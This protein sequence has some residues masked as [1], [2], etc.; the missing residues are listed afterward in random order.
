MRDFPNL[1]LSAHPLAAV[2]LARLRD[3]TTAPPAFRTALNQVA[4]LLVAEA[5]ADLPLE[6]TTV[7]TPLASAPAARLAAPV[8][9]FPV[10]RAGLGLL[11]AAQALLPDAPVWHVGLYRDE[12]TLQPVAY[13]ERLP[14]LDPATAC[15]ALDP[16][17]ATGGSAIAVVRL[18]RSRGA[19]LIR[20]VAVLAAPEGLD[21]L[22]AEA[23]EVRVH[24]AAVDDHLNERGFIVPGLG[25]AGDRQ[26]TA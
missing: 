9:F 18:L 23:P 26:F 19:R 14:S 5:T 16:M 12:T 13:Y 3:A 2:A 1:Q 17:L 24:V 7:A 8:A 22:H 15:Y 4:G 6:A 10:L 21:A 11:P 25:D 20:L